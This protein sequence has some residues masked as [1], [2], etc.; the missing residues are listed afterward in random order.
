MF[1]PEVHWANATVWPIAISSRPRNRNSSS[2]GRC[3]WVFSPSFRCVWLV[4]LI[5]YEREKLARTVARDYEIRPAFERR[6]NK[7]EIFAFIFKEYFNFALS[8]S[9]FKVVNSDAKKSAKT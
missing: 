2:N 1:T 9:N 7:T 3:K 4:I 5:C 8:Y 6:E